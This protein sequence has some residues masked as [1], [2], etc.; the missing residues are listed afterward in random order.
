[1]AYFGGIG[2]S[3]G[4]I[5]ESVCLVHAS[6]FR[7]QGIIRVWISQQ[8]ANR[9]KNLQEIY[10][11]WKRYNPNPKSLMVKEELGQ[12]N[13]PCSERDKE[14]MTGEIITPLDIARAN[15]SIAVDVGVENLCK[16]RDLSRT[17]SNQT[18]IILQH[19]RR[20]LTFKP[21]HIK[22]P[23]NRLYRQA[24]NCLLFYFIL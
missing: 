21:Q 17:Q 14:G 10:S 6:N 2:P 12:H 8:W 19:K 7:H 23:Q 16:E 22:S 24:N 9:Q 20:E 1:M 3:S 11:V 5:L 4:F 13:I 18:K 15:A